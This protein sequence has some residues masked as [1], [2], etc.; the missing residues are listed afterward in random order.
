M[1]SEIAIA[2]SNVALNSE[3]IGNYERA[4]RM[5]EEGIAI[6][7]RV[8]NKTELAN[9]YH[10]RGVIALREGNIN[11]AVSS[12]GETLALS[13]EVGYKSCE[14]S[15]LT[16]LGAV[17]CELEDSTKAGALLEEALNWPKRWET[18]PRKTG[19]NWPWDG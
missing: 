13:R 17:Y 16:D 6:A 7:R 3:R 12:L 10:N 15:S 19:Q 2:L 5:S 18:L 14:L 8:G 1:N 11:R 9:Q 4:N